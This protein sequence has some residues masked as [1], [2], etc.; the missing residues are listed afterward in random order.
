MHLFGFLIS[1]TL[2]YNFKAV[3]YA[4]RVWLWHGTISQFNQYTLLNFHRKFGAL[5]TKWK[6]SSKVVAQLLY[7][8]LLSSWDLAHVKDYLKCISVQ[9]LTG[10]RS[11][12]TELWSI[13]R[14]KRSKVCYANRVNHWKELNE[15]WYVG[16]VTIVGG[17]FCGL[18]GIRIKTTEIWH[19]TQPV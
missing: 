15:T 19:K 4:P 12:F 14:V 17:P 1:L 7:Y 3:K 5:I 16:G 10:I 8:I 9:I 11:R 18:K 13:F 2:A 6:I